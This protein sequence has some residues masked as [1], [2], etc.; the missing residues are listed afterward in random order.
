MVAQFFIYS[1]HTYILN[2]A[3]GWWEWHNIAQAWLKYKRKEGVGAG[4]MVFPSDYDRAKFRKIGSLEVLIVT[5]Y[6]DYKAGNFNARD[7]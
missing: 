7:M 2:N 3:S 1:D 5:G 6:S 4:Q